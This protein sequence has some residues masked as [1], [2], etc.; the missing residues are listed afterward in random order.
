M[1]PY[2]IRFNMIL[3]AKNLLTEQYHSDVNNIKEQYFAQRDAGLDVDFPVLPEFPSFADIQ[4][5][6]TEMNQFVSSK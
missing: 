2:E 3:E 1:S 5:L 6:A 4:K